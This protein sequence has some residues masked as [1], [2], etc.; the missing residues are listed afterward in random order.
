M[1]YN[2]RP[3]KDPTLAAIERALPIE[4]LRYIYFL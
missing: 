3:G 2:L 1:R 4:L